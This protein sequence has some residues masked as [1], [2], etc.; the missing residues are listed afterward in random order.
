MLKL[1]M[2]EFMLMYKH[3]IIKNFIKLK[4]TLPF[5]SLVL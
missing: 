5:Q 3:I 2:M 1:E 4:N